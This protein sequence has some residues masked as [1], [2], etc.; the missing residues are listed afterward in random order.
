MLYLNSQDEKPINVHI[1]SIGDPIDVGM[2]DVTAGMMSVTAGLA[3]YDTMRNLK[4]EISTIG[5]GQV[6]G[7]AALIMA[8]GTPG[9]RASLPHTSVVLSQP[10]MG[11]RGQ[12]SDIQGSATEMTAKKR[13]VVDLFAR[14]TGQTADRLVKDFDRT[15]YMTPDQAKEYGLIDRVIKTMKDVEQPALAASR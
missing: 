2:A 10:Q 3:I 1:N 6:V 9:K 5:M 11:T 8:A 14:H 15:F 4:S 12:A 7:M 13:L